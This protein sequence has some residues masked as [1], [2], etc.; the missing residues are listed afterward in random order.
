MKRVVY[1]VSVDSRLDDS[2]LSPRLV[3]N[4]HQNWYK[5]RIRPPVANILWSSGHTLVYILP[6]F[7]CSWPLFTG[8]KNVYFE[9]G[10]LS[11]QL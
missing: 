3:F 10:H 2:V 6:V 8:V 7:P 9:Q 1:K 11:T 5:S 4:H